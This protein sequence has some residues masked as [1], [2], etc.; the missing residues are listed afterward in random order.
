[1]PEATIRGC[2]VLTVTDVSISFVVPG[3]RILEK[4]LIPGTWIS[5]DF[6]HVIK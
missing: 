6:S 3:T 4:V 5:R 2:H 1:V